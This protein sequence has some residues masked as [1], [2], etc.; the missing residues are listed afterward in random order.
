MYSP[1]PPPPVSSTQPSIPQTVAHGS[2]TVAHSPS[3]SAH[4]TPST[5]GQFTHNPNFPPPS[6]DNGVS[7]NNEMVQLK[8]RLI[9]AESDKSVLQE[10]MKQFTVEHRQKMSMAHSEIERL[11]MESNQYQLMTKVGRYNVIQKT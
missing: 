8:Q 1:P 4:A 5:I 7:V 2:S 11:K 9:I 3:T 6:I 10:Q